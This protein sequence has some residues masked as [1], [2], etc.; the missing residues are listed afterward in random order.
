[1]KLVIIGPANLGPYHYARLRGVSKLFQEVTYVRVFIKGPNRPWSSDLGDKP[2]KIIGCNKEE[3]ISRL[4]AKENPDIIFTIGY[5]FWQGLR[6]AYWAKRNRVTSVLQCDST[7]EDHPRD[8]WK[9]W[10]KS[11][12]V[13]KLFDGAFVAGERS[14]RYIRSLGM[15]LSSIWRG[16]DVVDNKHFS[17]PHEIWKKPEKF[18]DN[19]FLTVGRLSPEKNILR[20]LHAFEI[21][22]IKGG[23]WGLVIAGTGPDENR[24]RQNTSDRIKDFVCWYGWAS[25]IKLPSLY[26][27][28]SCFILPSL[29]EPWGLVVNE[30]MAAS[31]PVLVSRNCGC[32]P[33]LCKT[34]L[35]GYSFDPMN[36]MQIAEQMQR[37]SSGNVDLNA[38]G[39]TSKQIVSDFTPEIWGR[40]I[41]DIANSHSN[42]LNKARLKP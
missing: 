42:K 6:A 7:Y 39:K 33:E 12:I 9:E 38:M 2:C 26:H 22:R 32:V 41:A 25:Y 20:L 28:A 36:T 10:V 13:K 27:G 21:Y 17:I 3:D 8:W 40:K 19:Y 1:M 11:V 23:R 37:M 15:S 14:A 16:V 30:A 5:N 34:D 35:N 24:L 29:S 18:S 31:L 4:L